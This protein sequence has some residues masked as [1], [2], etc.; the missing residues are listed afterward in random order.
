MLFDCVIKCNT[1]TSMDRVLLEGWLLS[2]GIQHRFGK[3]G[4]MLA[5]LE[6][7]Q[8]EELR[9]SGWVVKVL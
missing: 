3:F 5:K 1:Y 4:D 8:I 6:W 7:S 9:E 2:N